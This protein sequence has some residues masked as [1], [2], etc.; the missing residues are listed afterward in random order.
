MTALPSGTVTLFFTDVEGSTRLLQELD[1]GYEAALAEHHRIVRR[2]FD[3]HGGCEVDTQGEAFFAAF[4][5]ASDAVAAAVDVQRAFGAHPFRVRIGVHTGQPRIAETGYVGLD[6][7]RGARICAAGHGGQV[8]LS[9]TTRELIG[10]EFEVRDLGMHRLKD[11]SQPQRLYQLVADGVA[12]SFPPLRTLE[13]RP[14]NLPVQPTPLIGREREL[15]AVTSLVRQEQVRL[16]T[17]TGAAGSGKT[18][19]ALQASAELIEGF[20]DGVFVVGFVGVADSELVLPTVAQTLGVTESGAS[21]L[22]DALSDFLHDK[23]AL[24][25]LDNLEHLLEAAPLLGDLLAAAPGLKLLVTS[26]AALRLTAE[27]DY[28]VPPLSLPDPDRL[29]E[30]ASFARYESVALFLDRA[31][32]VRPDFEVSADNA[33]AIAAICARLDGLPLA[34][35]LA[36]ARIRILTP[37][38]MLKRLGQRLALLTGGARD[39]PSHQRT[40]RSAIDWSYELLDEDVRRLLARLSVFAGGC[41]LEAAEAVCD[42]TLPGLEALI[43]ENLLQQREQPW[44]G[45]PRFLLLETIREYAAERLEEL[46]EGRETRRRHAEYLVSWLEPRDDE[47]LE[48]TLIGQYQQEDA[49]QENARAALAWTRD[50]GEAELSLRLAAA[51]HFYWF[52]RFNLSEGRR[53]LDTALERGSSAP[54]GLRARALLASGRLA[55]P[56]GDMEQV[57]AAAEEASAIFA[58]E[59]DRLRLAASLT[60]LRHAAESEGKHD[61]ARSLEADAEAIYRELGNPTGLSRVLN[62]RGYGE[63][64][65][66]N[67]E[68]A[69]ALLRESIALGPDRPSH[70][71]LNLGL[72]LL[73]SGRPDEAR[74]AFGESLAEGAS[75]E[76]PEEV[77]Y[78]LEGLASVAASVPEDETAARLWGASEAVRESIGVIL[79]PAELALHERLVPESRARLGSHRFADAWAE[80]KAMPTEQAVE[81][82]LGTEVVR[83]GGGTRA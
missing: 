58:S 75:A 55:W 73:G 26:R 27:H 39:L 70:V 44:D 4:A 20:A 53:W 35:E 80:G 82:A 45:Q 63:L 34:I 52:A 71:L 13:S 12:A 21:P 61:D 40:L 77:L 24:L 23:Q 74:A 47:R 67:Y 17:L 79:A 37:Q 7:P 68:T 76:T 9:Q 46:G 78:A 10:D 32:A 18:R 60:I 69:E 83:T 33:P 41:T 25:V 51:L 36:A 19:L 3:R 48:G 14:T 64:V 66:G 16:V 42:A 57:R 38:A 62:N 49:E 8:L 22:A 11:L 56:Q 30:L 1:R 31:R 2:E 81:L 59:G 54:P 72:A 6:V 15:A 65:L 28:P 5:R 43:G 29:P 50:A